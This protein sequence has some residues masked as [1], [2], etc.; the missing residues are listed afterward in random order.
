[1][2]QKLIKKDITQNKV[3]H[4]SL[5]TF[6]LLSAILM[7][8]GVGIVLNVSQSNEQL[9]TKAK[10]P[11]FVQM[12]VGEVNQAMIDEWSIANPLVQEQQTVEMVNINGSALFLGNSH[13]PESNSVMDVSIVKQNQDFDFLVNVDNEMVEIEKGEIGVPIFYKEK[14]QV[15]IGDTVIIRDGKI[16]KQFTIGYFIKDS[17][18]NPAIIHSKRFLVHD[19][20]FEE[21]RNT[22]GEIEYLIEFSLHDKS[23]IADFHS[24]YQSSPLPQTGP[25][26][27]IHSI[28][29]L[30]TVSDGMVAMLLIVVSFLVIVIALLCTRLVIVATIEESYKEIGV[31]KAIGIKQSDIHK[32]Y[33][34]KYVL[35]AGVA[36]VIGFSVSIVLRPFLIQMI[37]SSVGE[38][39]NR[40][41]I[42]SIAFLSC[43]FLFLVVVL[44]CRLMVGKFK[45]ISAIDALHVGTLGGSVKGK[46]KSIFSL[47]NNRFIDVNVFIG[48]KAVVSRATLYVLLAFVFV[49]S[50]MMI[51]IPVHVLNL[52]Q[53]P[54]VTSY[55]GIGKSDVRI[56]IQYSED[57][58]ER[59]QDIIENLEMDND[60]SQFSPMLTS[61][62]KVKN[63]DGVFENINIESGDFSMFPLQYMEGD[64]PT[65]ENEIGLSYLLGKELEKKVGDNVIIETAGG[66]LHLTVSGIY[67]DITHGG[68]TA[69]AMLPVRL[70]EVIWSV[71]NINVKDGVH[72]S[73]KR[74]EYSR[75][76]YPIKVTS[77]E[78]YLH[79]TLGEVIAQLRTMT[80]IFIVVATCLTFVITL[81]FMKMLLAKE[82]SQIDIMRSIGFSKYQIQVQYVTRIMTIFVL[83]LLVGIVASNTFGP[84]LV[85]SILSFMGA[86][87]I[88]FIIN[89][90]Q[91]YVLGPFILLATVITATV[92]SIQTIRATKK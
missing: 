91:T 77:I 27:D 7:S 15:Q 46:R 22:I 62:F 34:Y 50:T 8:S 92:I 85:S 6:I 14:N 38:P 79:E 58:N 43:L 73:Q 89:P 71:I 45:K 16:T 32:L 60:I 13:T 36:S 49:L 33:L 5:F 75:L 76:F 54:T 9:V 53:A 51:L 40:V 68:R 1:M 2:L 69:K 72:I 55:M 19:D 90:F 44:F 39:T 87:K 88:E 83:S 84:F 70:E 65:I 64:A 47:R 20:D 28:M 52:M 57:M 12:H 67:Q 74:A 4:I 3:I 26:V 42:E 80:M 48:I 23:R 66:E 29:L 17:L 59:F 56:D 81:L 86:A 61:Q 35:I 18:M 25:A 31:L 30:Y 24:M 63:N 37:A 41:I 78:E 10:A 21:L 11:D 82:A